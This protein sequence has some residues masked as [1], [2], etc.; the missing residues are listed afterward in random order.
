[1][2]WPMLPR[3]APHHQPPSLKADPC[4]RAPDPGRTN[5]YYEREPEKW[6]ES[7]SG[8]T[9]DSKDLPT[10]G[11]PVTSQ[12]WLTRHQGIISHQTRDDTWGH[13][14]SAGHG[15]L[16]GHGGDSVGRHLQIWNSQQRPQ[17]FRSC[18]IIILEQSLK[19]GKSKIVFSEE[20]LYTVLVWSEL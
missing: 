6:P 7:V 17:V 8:V 19:P 15:P 18:K 12:C 11:H 13:G 20:V 9:S 10:P 5:I 14:D 4:V 2:I 1:M 16:T 3:L